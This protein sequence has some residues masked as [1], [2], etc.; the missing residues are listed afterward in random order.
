[1]VLAPRTPRTFHI[2]RRAGALSAAVGGDDDDELL[3]PKQVAA[4][5]G[6]SVV[7]LAKRRA[8]GTGPP[9]TRI[10]QRAVRYFRSGLRPWLE[11]RD[12]AAR[13]AAALSAARRA[14]ARQRAEV[15][16]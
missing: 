7:W 9:F 8:D 3:T 2:D 14:R 5:I 4:L 6:Y 16:A 12:A 13:R 10:N 15:L 1:M 11:K